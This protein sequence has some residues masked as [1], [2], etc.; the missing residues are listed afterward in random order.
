MLLLGTG[1]GLVFAQHG[2]ALA[3]EPPRC[4]TGD[5]Q[6]AAIAR[7]DAVRL[8]TVLRTLHRAPREVVKAKLCQEP[9]RLVY[10]L[11]LLGRDGKVKRMTVDA[12]NGT[13]VGER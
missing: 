13:V 10:V 4:M 3:A 12:T 8:A 2:H 6:R 1:L 7:G 11:T 5:G 9:T